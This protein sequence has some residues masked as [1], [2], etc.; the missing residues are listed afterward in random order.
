MAFCGFFSLR[1][2]VKL[3]ILNPQLLK[4]TLESVTGKINYLKK[5]QIIVVARNKVISSDRKCTTNVTKIERLSVF[6][7]ESQTSAA[8]TA[9]SGYSL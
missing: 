1:F 6:Y 9:C 7:N 3:L 4:F 5:L 2:P 8:S